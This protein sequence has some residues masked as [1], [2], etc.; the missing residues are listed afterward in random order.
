MEARKNEGKGHMYMTDKM[1]KVS[2][3]R[4]RPF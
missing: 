3:K 4:P 1:V 2:L